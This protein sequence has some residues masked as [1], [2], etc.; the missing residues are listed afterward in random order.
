MLVINMIMMIIIEVDM[1]KLSRTIAESVVL[2]DCNTADMSEV[3][4]WNT[5]RMQVVDSC[6]HI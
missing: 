1:I 3:V 4:V 6:V 5:Y 2:L